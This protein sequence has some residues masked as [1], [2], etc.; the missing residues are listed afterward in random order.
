MRLFGEATGGNRRG[1]NEGAF[2]FVNLPGSGITSI[3]LVGYYPTT[4]EPDAGL[5]PDVFVSKFADDIAHGKDP[6][7][8]AALAWIRSGR[9]PDTEYGWTSSEQL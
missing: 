5:D 9:M 1:I 7:M 4:A 3:F 8:E 6:A 2:F